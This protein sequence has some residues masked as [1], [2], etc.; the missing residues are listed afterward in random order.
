VICIPF[1]TIFVYERRMRWACYVVNTDRNRNA[2]RILVGNPKGKIQLVC[3][4]VCF[5]GGAYQHCSHEDL[6]YSNPPMEFRHSSPEALH[7][8][9]HEDTT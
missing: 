6:L 4:F 1:H 8:K 9:R 2:Y 7:T 5:G 3:L